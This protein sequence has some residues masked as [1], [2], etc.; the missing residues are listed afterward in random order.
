MSRCHHYYKLIAGEEAKQVA[1]ALPNPIGGAVAGVGLL[2]AGLPSRTAYINKRGMFITD[3]RDTTKNPFHLRNKPAY[4]PDYAVVVLPSDDHT[5]GYIRNL[6]PPAH[7][8]IRPNFIEDDAEQKRAKGVFVQARKELREFIESQIQQTFAEEKLNAAALAAIV[9]SETE[10]ENGPGHR[11]PTR[12]RKQNFQ[13]ATSR[14]S[15]PEPPPE[16]PAPAPQPP[17]PE[18]NPQPDLEPQPDPEP[19][20]EPRPK[21]PPPS[22][23]SRA[24]AISGIRPVNTGPR[25]A[26]IMFTTNK[27]DQTVKLQLAPSGEMDSREAGLQLTAAREDQGAA[28]ALNGDVVEI[29]AKQARRYCIRLTTADDISRTALGI[30]NLA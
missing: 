26:A 11:L 27:P 12:T 9:S 13:S 19:K 29:Q 16:P 10:E 17:T 30:R 7:D 8:E 24:S 25:E 22:P 4:C 18:P 21:P 15:T 1:V 28:V 20:P 5:Q 6:E 14:V 3:S 2:E 23:A